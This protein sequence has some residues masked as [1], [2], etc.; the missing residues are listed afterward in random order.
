MSQEPPDPHQ[1]ALYVNL[2]A[3]NY[4]AFAEIGAGQE[5]ARWF[6]R[7]GGAAGTVAK[8]TSAYDMT[9]S[10]AIYGPSD[11]YV[12]RARLGQMLDR[13]YGLVIERLARK[14]GAGT[15]FFAFA[16]TVAARSYSRLEETHGWMGIRFQSSPGEA[17]SQIIIHVSMLDGEAVLQ[18]E[19]LGI[20][21]VNLV[22]GALYLSEDP[23]ALLSSLMDGLSSSRIEVDMVKVEGPAFAGV[24][25]R[26]LAVQL[27]Q[28]GLAQAT[29]L[30][31]TGEVVQGAEVLYRKPI[32]AVRGSFRP[33]T[34]ATVDLIES[35]KR[36]FASEP[37]VQGQDVVVLTEMTLRHLAEGGVIDPR[38]FLDRADTL[39]ALGL[40]VLVSNYARYFR[41]AAYLV[42]HNRQMIGVAMG[43]RRLRE[44]L[45]ESYYTDLAG[46]ILEAFGRM[47]KNDLKLYIYPVRETD[48]DRLVT[49][50]N[51]EVAP[52]LQ[53]LR[54]HLL[55]NHHVEDIRGYSPDCLDV[56]GRDVLR[57]IRSGDASWERLV[58]GQV[59]QLIRER[60]LFGCSA[61]GNAA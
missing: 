5:V 59:V 15:R 23:S 37:S 47:F 35:A 11:R 31:A 34:N 30:T 14:R 20:V 53:H 55:D 16:D 54:A 29:M 42:A 26:V 2:D 44:M 25:N 17:A 7:V 13:E 18:Q 41:L 40:S 60:A 45:D 50:A 4:G 22:Y 27:V 3:A 57:R 21:G 9:I 1:K 32:L 24:D 39:G 43:V 33:I 49:A 52:H 10:D 12:S 61:S 56:S 46:G 38:D 8:S 58:P 48:G 6:F 19:A 28:K 36:Q 51:V